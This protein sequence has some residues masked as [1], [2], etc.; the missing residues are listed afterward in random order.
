MSF[1][2]ASRT[3]DGR[4]VLRIGTGLDGYLVHNSPKAAAISFRDELILESKLSTAQAAGVRQENL[5]GW[6]TKCPA[7]FMGSPLSSFFQNARHMYLFGHLSNFYFETGLP[8][9]LMINFFSS[10]TS[11][12]SMDQHVWLTPSPAEYDEKW[13]KI[14]ALYVG[15][16]T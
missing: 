16:I 15:G 1:M 3:W 7:P 5:A 8:K 14:V 6:C 13:E 10:S 12:H 11:A 9:K 4:W 2:W